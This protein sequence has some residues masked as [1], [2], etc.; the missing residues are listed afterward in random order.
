MGDEKPA[1]GGA[2]SPPVGVM[3]LV[4]GDG[5]FRLGMLDGLGNWRARHGGPIR[6]KPTRWWRFPAVQTGNLVK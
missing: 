5:G 1:P 3:L 4:Y 6:T 2:E